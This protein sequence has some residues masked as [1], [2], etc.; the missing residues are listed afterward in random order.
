MNIMR[1]FFIFVVF[2]SGITFADYEMR[3]PIG[4]KTVTEQST[5]S[6]PAF[7]LQINTGL[8]GNQTAYLLPS[9]SVNIAIDWGSTAANETCPTVVTSESIVTCVYDEPGI[10]KVKITG[11]MTAYGSSLAPSTVRHR[12][13]T[14]NY[15]T[16][17]Y[18]A[19]TSWG[20][21]GITSLSHAF[22]DSSNLTGLPA[23]L[24]VGLNNVQYLLEG[25]DSFT[26][27]ISGWGLDRFSD[28]SYLFSSNNGPLPDITG[29]NTSNVTSLKGAFYRAENFNQPIG[30]WDVSNVTDFSW[31]FNS[32]SA[33][34]Q[35]LNDWDMSSAVDLGSMFAYTEAF[36][37]P[38]DKWNTANVEFMD[39]LFDSAI[40]FNQP[41]NDW[42]VSKVKSFG[43]MFLGT[44]AFNQPINNWNTASAET[45][46]WMFYGAAA[47]NQS[48]ANLNLS[49][50]KPYGLEK[51]LFFNRD[52]NKSLA[53][54]NVVNFPSEPKDFNAHGSFPAE[55]MPIWGTNGADGT[56]E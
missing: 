1:Y 6:D 44:G 14:I 42:D 34:N 25:A 33:F 54:W 35:P 31:L 55:K 5:D 24:P 39:G 18:A 29:L 4:V 53:C 12:D 19:I 20:N 28:W 23:T 38:L 21:V 17:N 48:L 32:A 10:Y 16:K 43:S 46:H 50:L 2:Y 47:F 15:D 45:Y 36:N 3:V 27:D 13:T 52:F 26:G 7:T 9:G 51:F 30:G 8:S 56:C 41:L 22:R 37:Q 49:N 11:T 40:V